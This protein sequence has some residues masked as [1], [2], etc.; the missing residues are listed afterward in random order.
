M[1]RAIIHNS[2]YKSVDEAKAA[3]DRYFAERNDYF[4]QPPPRAGKKTGAKS[5][6]PRPF[7]RLITAKTQDI[8]DASRQVRSLADHI[9]LEP[10]CAERKFISLTSG[11]SSDSVDLVETYSALI[12]A[13]DRG[14]VQSPRN[15][16]AQLGAAETHSNFDRHTGLL[17][18]VPLP[19][20]AG[21]PL[22]SES[23]QSWQ[24]S[25]RSSRL[26]SDSCGLL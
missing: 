11:A 19:R 24:L 8:G 7:L 26:G 9:G 22:R 3:I 21:S 23:V 4:R 2:D 12:C 18:G 15:S 14:R 1:A 13:V 20:S 25:R 10:R 17:L 5:V 16:C 6:N